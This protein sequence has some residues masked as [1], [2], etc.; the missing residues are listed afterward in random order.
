MIIVTGGAGFIG[1]AIIWKLNQVGIKDILVVDHFGE[2]QKYQNLINLKYSDVMDKED[3]L[4]LILTSGKNFFNADT[5]FHMG[6]CSSTTEY[7]FEYLLHNNFE[8][9]KFLCEYS[10]KHKI[11][12]IYASSAATYGNGDNGYNDDINKLELLNPLNPYGYSKHIFDLWIKNKGYVK[13]VTGLKYFNVFGPNEYHKGDM[14]SVVFKCFN[15]IKENGKAKLFKTTSEEYGDG[16]Q[17]RDFLYVKD[18]VDM[19]L[20]FY[21]NKRINGIYN[22]GTGTANT[23]N[24]FIKPIFTVLKRKENIVYFGIINISSIK[25]NRMFHKFFHFI[26]VWS[27]IFT[28][29]CCNNESINIFQGVVIIFIE[30]NFE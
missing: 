20:F 7:D 15:Q 17:K 26:K 1:S 30:F 2:N 6:A 25:N 3:F 29:F 5:I 8:Y 16:E 4:D 13:K 27:A 10:L 22:I 9:S 24:S 12:F 19:T 23:F 11:K 14:C 28:P 21:L 18:A